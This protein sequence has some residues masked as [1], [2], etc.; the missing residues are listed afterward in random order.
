VVRTAWAVHRGIYRFSGG[1]LG[2]RRPHGDKWGAM[3]LTT[4]GPRSGAERTRLWERWREIDRDLDGYASQRRTPTT[5]V[6]LEPA[7]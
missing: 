3:R 1:R 7:A 2:L 4:L 6:I 5:V